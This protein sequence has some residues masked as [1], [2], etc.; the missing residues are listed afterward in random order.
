MRYETN[1][2]RH[3]GEK[4]ITGSHH[5]PKTVDDGHWVCRSSS[6][7]AEHAAQLANHSPFIQHKDVQLGHTRI[8]VTPVAM[9]DT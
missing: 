4:L 3:R 2:V 6:V 1:V 7:L 9:K 5:E 8:N